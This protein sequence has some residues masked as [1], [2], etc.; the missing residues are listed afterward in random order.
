MPKVK[1]AFLTLLR[2]TKNIKYYKNS[3]KY[4]VLI[5]WLKKCPFCY[6]KAI[7]EVE[8]RKWFCKD[9]LGMFFVIKCFS[10]E[11]NM[12]LTVSSK[13]H[14]FKEYKLGK[15]K[16]DKHFYKKTTRQYYLQLIEFHQEAL[17]EWKERY[18]KWKKYKGK[19]KFEYGKGVK[20]NGK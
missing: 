4:T 20:T 11:K 8:K 15:F 14:I 2:W 6:S 12:H 5:Q 1:H 13:K 18:E 17:K 16:E 3:C 9:C 7:R 19:N 10:C